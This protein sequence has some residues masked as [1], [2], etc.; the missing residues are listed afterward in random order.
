MVRIGSQDGLLAARVL[1]GGAQG[2][3][4]HARM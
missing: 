1:D 2:L 3:V 4:A